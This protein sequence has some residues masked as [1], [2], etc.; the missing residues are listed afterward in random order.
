M[1]GG[2]SPGT[3]PHLEGCGRLWFLWRF[4]G[5][6]VALE[7]PPRVSGRAEVWRLP[8]LPGDARWDGGGGAKV[9]TGALV[10]ATAVCLSVGVLADVLLLSRWFSVPVG[11]ILGALVGFV[12]GWRSET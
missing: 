11:A 5:G 8:E 3:V 4:P 1:S 7:C 10:Y 9:M 6:G 2:I 12:V